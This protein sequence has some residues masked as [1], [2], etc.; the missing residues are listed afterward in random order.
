LE[1]KAV[2]VGSGKMLIKIEAVFEQLFRSLPTKLPA[3]PGDDKV[4]VI[5]LDVAPVLRVYVWA[6]EALTVTEACPAQKE[7]GP[8]I[9]V[10]GRGRTVIVN[11]DLGS[12]VQVLAS[13]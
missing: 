3:N 7:A 9:L 6:P 10:Y 1:K 2:I 12:S 13:A 4:A 5:T 8:A 11:I